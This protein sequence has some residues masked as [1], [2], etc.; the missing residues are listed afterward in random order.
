MLIWIALKRWQDS[1]G[2]ILFFSTMFWKFT[3]P[4]VHLHLICISHHPSVISSHL[5]KPPSLCP[6]ASHLH[7]ARNGIQ[8]APHLPQARSNAVSVLFPASVDTGLTPVPSRSHT[9]TTAPENLPVQPTT[10]HRTQ[11]GDSEERTPKGRPHSLPL[12]LPEDNT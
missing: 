11:L 10:V 6:S 5:H 3:T 7:K 9:V 1:L 2:H 4:Y 8:N 12:L